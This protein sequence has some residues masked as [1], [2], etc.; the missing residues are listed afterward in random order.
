MDNAVK[1]KNASRVKS[2]AIYKQFL[3]LDLVDINTE[4]SAIYALEKPTNKTYIA[5][6]KNRTLYGAMARLLF[7]FGMV[8]I[9]MDFA[10]LKKDLAETESLIKNIHVNKPFKFI[11]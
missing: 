9:S 4:I 10:R 6:K 3:K 7:N 8:R 5:L 1:N 11:K 2:L